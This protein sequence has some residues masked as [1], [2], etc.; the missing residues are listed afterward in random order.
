MDG[1]I[2]AYVWMCLPF[3]VAAG[4]G[5]LVAFLMQARMQV[6]LSRQREVLAETRTLVVTQHRVME[7]RIRAAEEAARRKALDDFMADIRIEERHYIRESRSLLMNQRS[8][9]VQ[10]RIY[11]RN[12]PL[13]DWTEREFQVAEGFGRSLPPK[14]RIQPDPRSAGNEKLLP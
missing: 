3:V 5:L 8:L 9:V 14:Q 13:S 4:S 1:P 7:D 6:A 2:A 10:E 12:I 11:F